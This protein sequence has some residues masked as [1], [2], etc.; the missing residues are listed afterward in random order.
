MLD[1]PSPAAARWMLTGY[2]TASMSSTTVPQSLYDSTTMALDRD[3][4]E[5]GFSELAT[6]YK[7]FLGYTQPSP[8]DGKITYKP[9]EVYMNK[10]PITD[11]G[12]IPNRFICNGTIAP[13]FPTGQLLVLGGINLILIQHGGNSYLYEYTTNS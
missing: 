6:I 13:L 5:L 12:Y 9:Q 11:V 8:L 4:Y 2:H 3:R 1:Y 7:T 10:A